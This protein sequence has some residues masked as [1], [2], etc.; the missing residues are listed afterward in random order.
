MGMASAL[1]SAVAAIVEAS[2]DAAGLVARMPRTHPLAHSASARSCALSVRHM[3]MELT[4]V[5][6]ATAGAMGDAA[7]LAVMMPATT[8]L[9]PSALLALLRCN[10]R[11]QFFFLFS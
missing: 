5:A 4:S 8:Q 1:T 10:S 7:G 2:E 3:A 6:V 11:D 9:A